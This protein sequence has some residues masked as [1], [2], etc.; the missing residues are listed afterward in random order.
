MLLSECGDTGVTGI[1]GLRI[2]ELLQDTVGMGLGAWAEIHPLVKGTEI[3]LMSQRLMGERLTVFP[4][5]RCG[6]VPNRK[7]RQT[8]S[9]HQSRLMTW[10]PIASGPIICCGTGLISVMSVAEPPKRKA[11]R[12]VVLIRN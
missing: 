3:Q 2:L 4:K 10:T 1:G 5:I 6:Q 8:F 9:V 11:R 7:F 12:L